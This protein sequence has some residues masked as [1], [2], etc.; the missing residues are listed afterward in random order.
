VDISEEYRQIW[1]VY[2]RNID[3]FGG[4][5]RKNCLNFSDVDYFYVPLRLILKAK[6]ELP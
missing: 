2:P 4:Y 1:W 3:K 6:N 5:I